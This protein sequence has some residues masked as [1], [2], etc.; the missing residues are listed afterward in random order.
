MVF[1]WKDFVLHSILICWNESVIWI[2]LLYLN[3]QMSVL[4]IG[5]PVF[6]LVCN[7]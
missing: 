7:V 2:F 1:K 3:V 4:E 5:K 6:I